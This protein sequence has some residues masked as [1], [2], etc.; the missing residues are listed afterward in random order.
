MLPRVLSAELAQEGRGEVL[1][2]KD[3][4]SSLC[5]APHIPTLPS[6][7]HML[8]WGHNQASKGLQ[9]WVPDLEMEFNFITN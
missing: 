8:L 2:Y 6:S 7:S 4:F 9:P 3:T 1:P 5:W